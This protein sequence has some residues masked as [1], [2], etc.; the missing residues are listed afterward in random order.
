LRPR[1]L[2]SYL[3]ATLRI[4]KDRKDEPL[5]FENPDIVTAREPY[6]NYLKKELDDEILPHWQRW[7]EALQACSAI[8]TITFTRDQF[9][10]EYEKRRS[11]QN[12]MDPQQALKLLYQFSVIAY[13]RRSGYGGSS[14]SF[15][16]ID[17]AAGWDNSAKRFKVHL[18]LKEYAKLK[19]ERS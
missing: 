11:S 18:G 13:E 2:I 17:S 8:A 15:E 6:S 1:D 14:W 3:N 7:D 16:Y 10:Q 5:V 4:A 12:P 9:E 19:E